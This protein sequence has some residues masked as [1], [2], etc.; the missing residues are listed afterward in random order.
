MKANRWPHGLLVSVRDAEEAEVAVTAGAT[1][2]DVK[3]PRHGSLGRADASVAAAV[4]AAVRGRA[5]VTL[6][7]GELADGPDQIVAHLA[8]VLDSLPARATPPMAVKAGPAGLSV[9]AWRDAFSRLRQDLPAGVE[10]VAVAYADWR[11]AD[12]PGPDRIIAE[13]GLIGAATVLLDTFD[14]QGGG[15]F[16][17][18]AAQTLAGWNAAAAAGGLTLAVAGRL[19][20]AD[21]AAAFGIGLRI[22]GVRSAACDGGRDGRVAAPRVRELVTLACAAASNRDHFP[23]GVRVS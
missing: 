13:A 7:G 12:A 4:S 8:R 6:A 10:G 9:G 22:V 1:I 11:L 16:E 18:S 23:R 19:T 2:I 20:P 21:V 17:T 5:P 15:L 14:K 3:E